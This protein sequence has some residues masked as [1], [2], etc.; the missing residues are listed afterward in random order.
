[1]SKTDD[2]DLDFTNWTPPPEPPPTPVV[3]EGKP[4][5]RLIAT[6]KEFG[7]MRMRWRLTRVT[8]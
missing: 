4:Q 7:A 5:R 3:V 6:K 8:R 2:N 1:M